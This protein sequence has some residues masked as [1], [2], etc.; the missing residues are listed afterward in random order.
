[1]ITNISQEDLPADKAYLL[2]KVRWQIELT[3]KNWKSCYG[4]DKIHGV[5]YKRFMC[6]MYAKLTLMLIN[7][8]L[9]NL[10][11]PLYYK[12]YNKLLSKNKCTKTMIIYY[13]KLREA[14]FQ[15]GQKIKD[16]IQEMSDKLSKKHW[17]EKRK[18]RIN[19]IDLFELF[20][21]KL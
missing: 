14:M 12:R 13:N 1:M 7:N 5:N 15:G 19:Y 2:Y 8:Q 21:C 17:L 20:S 4:I 3:F 9:I 16:Y 18:H 10:L 6:F 11:E